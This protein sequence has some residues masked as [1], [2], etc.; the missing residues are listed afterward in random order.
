MLLFAPNSLFNKAAFKQKR[1]YG[2][3]LLNQQLYF[4][5]FLAFWHTQTYIKLSFTSF[6][7][8]GLHTKKILAFYSFFYV[9]YII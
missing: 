9:N 7:I 2:L 1:S 3:R 4:G 6:H 5:W 8:L